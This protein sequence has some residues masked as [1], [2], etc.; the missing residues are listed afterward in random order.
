MKNT[1]A[2]RCVYP[3]YKSVGSQTFI[4]EYICDHF[5]SALVQTKLA[6]S[7]RFFMLV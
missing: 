6:A 5:Q 7:A 3:R 1:L 4:V 2:L